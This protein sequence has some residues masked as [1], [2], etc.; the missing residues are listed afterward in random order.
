[1]L[2]LQQ[3]SGMSCRVFF[4]GFTTVGGEFVTDIE[5]GLCCK[6]KGGPDTDGECRDIDVDFTKA[7]M[8]DC[9][10]GF[11]LKGYQFTCSTMECLNKFRCCKMESGE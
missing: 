2:S 11:I 1:M 3:A 4:P 7:R 9:P 10:S 8:N 5:K 6:P